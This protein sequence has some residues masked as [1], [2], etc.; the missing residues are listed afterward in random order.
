MNY[1][2]MSGRKLETVP[3][4]FYYS[5]HAET[6]GPL[7][8][9]YHQESEVPLKPVPAS[10]I[11][12]DYYSEAGKFWIEGKYVAGDNVMHFLNIE[13]EYFEHLST[14]VLNGYATMMGT[15]DMLKVC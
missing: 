11:I 2:N 12:F 6:L 13:S 10:M 3:R 7:L 8:R 1:F 5:A 9:F 14:S 4:F 15:A